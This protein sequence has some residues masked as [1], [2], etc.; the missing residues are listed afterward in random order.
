MHWTNRGRAVQFL[1][2]PPPYIIQP[3]EER[4]SSSGR[5]SHARG[6]SPLDTAV[7]LGPGR[8]RWG[9]A[10]A[11]VSVWRS[12]HAHPTCYRTAFNALPLLPLLTFCLLTATY[13]DLH[14]LETILLTEYPGGCYDLT[15]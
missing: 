2:P 1:Q 5:L 15:V 7:I 4:L 6:A 12:A 9:T 13:N 14:Q 3:S 10:P 8:Q 11:S